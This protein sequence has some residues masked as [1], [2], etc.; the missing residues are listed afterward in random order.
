MLF[1]FE[2]T[3]PF[4]NPYIPQEVQDANL[5]SNF[6]LK[7]IEKDWSI[8]ETMDIDYTKEQKYVFQGNSIVEYIENFCKINQTPSSKQSNKGTYYD[9]QHDLL[10][11]LSNCYIFENNS[12][13][14]STKLAIHGI[15]IAKEFQKI[16]A[17]LKTKLTNVKTTCAYDDCQYLYVKL[18]EHTEYFEGK[19]RRNEL[20]KKSFKCSVL[21]KPM[22]LYETDNQLKL[23]WGL[24]R[25]NWEN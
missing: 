4:L 14:T 16:P 3:M 5:F 10:F 8:V 21:I 6:N 19:Y 22:W 20:P 13:Y 17:L 12:H 9:I 1:L 15:N 11:P 23:R 25:I 7:Y 18:T 24:H 2:H